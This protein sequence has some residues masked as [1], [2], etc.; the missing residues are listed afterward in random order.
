MAGVRVPARRV[1]LEL[2]ELGNN[3]GKPS[4]FAPA[5][6]LRDSTDHGPFRLAFLE[7]LWRTSEQRGR[8]MI[9]VALMGASSRSRAMVRL[10]GVRVLRALLH[11]R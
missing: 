4:C 9:R 1:V 8:G 11:A 2:M 6:A 5:A 10:L 7:A 3:G